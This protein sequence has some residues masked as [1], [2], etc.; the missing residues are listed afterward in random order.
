MK[1]QAGRQTGSSGGNLCNAL[2]AP[3]RP[4][5]PAPPP[6]SLIYVATGSDHPIFFSLGGSPEYA[7]GGFKMWSIRVP[8]LRLFPRACGGLLRV[9]N[10]LV[11][12]CV[13]CVSV[14]FSLQVCVCVCM[15]LVNYFYLVRWCLRACGHDTILHR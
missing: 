9:A 8:S 1:K 15:C 14:V 6:P 11:T 12:K 10:G 7:D 5:P 4:L 13:N 2:R 3:Q